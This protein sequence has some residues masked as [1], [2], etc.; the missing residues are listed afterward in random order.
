MIDAE[1]ALAEAREQD[2]VCEFC[3]YQMFDDKAYP[4]SRCVCNMPTENMFESKLGELVRCWYCE[5][6]NSETRGCIRNP[7]TEPWYE[8]DFCSYGNRRKP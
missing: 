1:R 6:Y 7:S 5:Y 2:R 3:Y 8:N 4:C